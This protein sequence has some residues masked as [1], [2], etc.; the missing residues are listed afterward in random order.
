MGITNRNNRVIRV[1]FFVDQFVGLCDSNNFVNALTHFNVASCK[2]GLITYNSN[3][4]DLGT[5]GKVDLKA[6]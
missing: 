6:L 2:L 5:F 1:E 4:S 3:N